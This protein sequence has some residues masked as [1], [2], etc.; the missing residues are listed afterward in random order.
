MELPHILFTYFTNSKQSL[1]NDS[2]GHPKA[3]LCAKTLQLDL[4]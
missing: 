2:L 3:T 1:L 4:E